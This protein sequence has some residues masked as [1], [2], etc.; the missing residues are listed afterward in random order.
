MHTLFLADAPTY[1]AL[2]AAYPENGAALAALPAGTRVYVEDM[3]CEVRRSANGKFWVPDRMPIGPVFTGSNAKWIGPA[4]TTAISSSAGHARKHIKPAYYRMPAGKPATI[5]RISLYQ[6]TNGTVGVGTDA[7]ALKLYAA[8][9]DGSPI[10]SQAPLYVWDWNSGG[11]GGAGTLSLAGAGA[12]GT[13]I[14]ADLPGGAVSVPGHFWLAFSHDLATAPTL[15]TISTTT[16][17]NEAAAGE[18]SG[19]DL[20]NTLSPNRAGHYAYDDSATGW[21]IGYAPVWGSW[22]YGSG[23]GAAIVA[24]LKVTG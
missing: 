12:N 11:T 8:N 16:T 19:S 15:S 4:N 17:F 13:R 10:L 5:S 21:A 24:H 3:S 22:E 1:A 6:A 20:A 7:C 9:P 23:G 2:I 14:H 18:L